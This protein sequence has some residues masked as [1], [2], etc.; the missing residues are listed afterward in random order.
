MAENSQS[1]PFVPLVSSNH[2]NVSEGAT[3]PSASGLDSSNLGGFQPM[4]IGV[5][6][7]NGPQTVNGNA[8][9]PPGYTSTGEPQIPAPEAYN[10]RDSFVRTLEVYPSL[11]K[12]ILLRAIG[13]SLCIISLG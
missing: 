7:G 5:N 10:A 3:M 8:P 12:V 2:A 1:V 6:G 13:A 11:K 4:R 9:G